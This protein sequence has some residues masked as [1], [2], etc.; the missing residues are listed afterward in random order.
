MAQGYAQATDPSVFVRFPVLDGTL[1]EADLL[2]WT[3]TPWTLISN[4]AVAVG[5][6]VRYVLAQCRSPGADASARWWSP[7]SG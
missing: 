6:S 7:R 5:P 3:T 4:V 2:V 1:A